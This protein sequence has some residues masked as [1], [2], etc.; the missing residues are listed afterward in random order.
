MASVPSRA[1]SVRRRLTE[2][3]VGVDVARCVALVGMICTHL[4][5]PMGRDGRITV[6][7]QVAGGRSAALFAVL[8]GVSTALVTG[9]AQPVAGARLT[10]ARWAL[11]VRAALIAALGLWLAGL[12]SGIA[13]ILPYYGVLFLLG[14]PFLRLRPGALAVLAAAVAVIVPVVS[15]LLR[16]HLPAVPLGQPTVDDLASPGPLLAD[17][18]FTG[19]YPAVAWTAYLFLGMALG[20]LRLRR[21]DVAVRVALSGAALAI[22][23]WLVGHLATGSHDRTGGAHRLAAP[24]GA[25]VAGRGTAAHRGAGRHDADRH[26]V[27]AARRRAALDDDLRP[28]PDRWQRDGRPRPVPARDPM[29]APVLVGGL[30]R[31]G[32]DAVALYL[33]RRARLEWHTSH[34]PVCRA[35]APAARA[36]DRCGLRGRTA[37]WPARMAGRRR[38]RNCR[39]C[40]HAG[41]AP[42]RGARL[43]RRPR[44]RVTTEGYWEDPA[45]PDVQQLPH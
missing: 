32:D 37:A 20:R 27:V 42:H 33:S 12:D 11:V 5:I 38:G 19:T 23:G 1:W 7:Q 18:T 34:R 24:E 31:R 13:V 29:A 40:L 22:G 28:G 36:R 26:V 14:V 44:R 10:R 35:V 8:A 17:L 21:P 16:P 39:R 45:H 15:H 6:L 2:R 43:A 3:I 41:G 30:R 9:G 25:A 4:V